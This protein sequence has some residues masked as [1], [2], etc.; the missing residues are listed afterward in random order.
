MT[1][2][3]LA[4]RFVAT[5]RSN[6]TDEDFAE[7]LKRN[8]TYPPGCCATHDFM[9]ANMLMLEAFEAL[10]KRDMDF[11]SDADTALWSAAWEIATT[12]YLTEKP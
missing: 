1:P 8:K 6:V 7:I 9:D 4:L 12:Q 2:E 10:A 5:V 11:E 3:E